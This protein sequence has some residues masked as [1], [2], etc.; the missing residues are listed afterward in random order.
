[1]LWRIW[2]RRPTN[3]PAAP[4]NTDAAFI[5][6]P[7]G[8]KWCSISFISGWYARIECRDGWEYCSFSAC[9]NFATPLDAMKDAVA[10]AWNKHVGESQSRT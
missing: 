5:A 7:P 9:R 8:Y 10:Q 4:M 2:K 1:M 6:L 3:N